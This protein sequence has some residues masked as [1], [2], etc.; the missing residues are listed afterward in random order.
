MRSRRVLFG[1]TVSKTEV[2]KSLMDA[3]PII[4]TAEKKYSVKE[5][6]YEIKL[7]DFC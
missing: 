4:S 5:L 2:K 6:P 3:A 1:R 7:R